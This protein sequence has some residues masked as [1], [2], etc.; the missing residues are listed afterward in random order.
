[1]SEQKL[2]PL[3]NEAA[4]T[5]P[6]VEVH[7]RVLS[8]KEMAIVAV[9]GTAAL[10]GAANILNGEGGR[11][12]IPAFEIHWGD[13]KSSSTDFTDELRGDGVS[14]TSPSGDRYKV[15]LNLPGQ[16]TETKVTT[17]N[18]TLRSTM[19]EEWARHFADDEKAGDLINPNEID[20]YAYALQELVDQGWT[21]DFMKTR[22]TT[23]AEDDTTNNGT[24]TAGLQ[25]TSPEAAQKQEELGDKRRN[26]GTI[27]L[28]AAL[29]ERG[30]KLEAADIELLESIED[31]LTDEE[32][33]V[34]DT[35]SKKFGYNNITTM[36]EEWNRDPDSLPKEVDKALTEI[37]F[38]E[39]TFQVE[40]G[41]SRTKLVPG[42][43]GP[44]DSEKPG[45]EDGEPVPNPG[46]Q[47]ESEENEDHE[48]RI[49]PFL[50]PGYLF[51]KVNS[52]RRPRFVSPGPSGG[53]GGGTSNTGLIEASE[54]AVMAPKPK[55]PLPVKPPV[56]VDRFPHRNGHKPRKKQTSVDS[57]Q[58]YRGKQPRNHNFSGRRGNLAGGPGRM[59]R[60][61]GGN[62]G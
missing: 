58:S 6:L 28:V 54:P 19:T 62:R 23:S 25:E 16:P 12:E 52:R 55:P 5:P 4:N 22:G 9:A 40:I 29:N 2:P 15:R 21:I 42:E 48:L 39:R 50:L 36:I 60:S 20:T 35:L 31:V 18:K 43:G 41:L 45:P 13:D 53:D 24:R 10:T 1:M 59:A 8:P 46:G 57:Q 61:H 44:D 38:I 47:A 11:P 3:Q 34:I 14:V 7:G 51:I 56:Y 27:E 26:I 49:L 37:L 17:E 32:V 33:A 30:I